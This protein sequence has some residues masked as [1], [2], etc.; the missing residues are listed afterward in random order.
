MKGRQRRRER[1]KIK[2][3]MKGRERKE[4]GREKYER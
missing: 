1:G 2:K 3:H 4:S